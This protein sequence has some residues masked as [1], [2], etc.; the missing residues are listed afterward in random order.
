MLTPQL[1]GQLQRVRRSAEP[2]CRDAR[3]KSEAPGFQAD[4]KIS[5]QRIAELDALLRRHDLS[6]VDGFRA[7]SAQLRRTMGA[8]A[9]GRM[10][11]YID[12]LK[13]GD[14]ADVLAQNT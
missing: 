7:L 9:Y 8:V 5:S 6:A 3:E 12:E 13:F 2:V 10:L 14:A 11:A 1:A 4:A